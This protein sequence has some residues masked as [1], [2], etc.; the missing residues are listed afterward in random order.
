MVDECIVGTVLYCFVCMYVD[1]E[2]RECIVRTVMYCFVSVCGQRSKRMYCKKC[3]F[4]LCVYVW[5]EK[6]ENV[7]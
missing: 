2:A 4:A 6:Q 5:T 1:R 3:C 7:L